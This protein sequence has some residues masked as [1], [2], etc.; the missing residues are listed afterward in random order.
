[1]DVVLNFFGQMALQL[2]IWAAA[3]LVAPS[4]QTPSGEIKPPIVVEV[5]MQVERAPVENNGT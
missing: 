1:M 3:A 2:V 4:T 5:Q